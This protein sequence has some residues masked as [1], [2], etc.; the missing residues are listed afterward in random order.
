MH[1]NALHKQQAMKRTSTKT[2]NIPAKPSEKKKTKKTTVD[3]PNV[4]DF[5][6]D[7]SRMETSSQMGDE[8]LD[9]TSNICA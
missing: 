4:E 7:A 2:D 1:I 8:H 5:E 3:E 6:F 9:K